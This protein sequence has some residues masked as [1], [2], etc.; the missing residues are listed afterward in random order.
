MY[1]FWFVK[2]DLCWVFSGSCWCCRVEGVVVVIDFVRG[3]VWVLVG[4]RDYYESNFNCV[5]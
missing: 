3:V 5:I 2:W 4:G 1:Y